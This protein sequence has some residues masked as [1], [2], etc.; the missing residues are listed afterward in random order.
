MKPMRSP[1]LCFV[2][3][4]SRSLEG[5]VDEHGAAYDIFTRNEAP[6]AAVKGRGAVV[7]HCEDFAGGER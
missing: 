2:H 5:P 7:A 1:T 6:V 3:L 4:V